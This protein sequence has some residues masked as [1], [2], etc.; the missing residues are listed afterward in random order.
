MTV[1][2]SKSLSPTYEPDMYRPFAEAL[3]YAFKCVSNI[4]VDGLPE[5]KAHIV[6]VPCDNPIPSRRESLF[7]PGLVI[8]S[9]QDARKF[10]QLEEVDAP[11]VSRFISEIEGRSLSGL[12]WEAV[13][14]AV[15]VK[16]NGISMWASLEVFGEQDGK[17][18]ATGG[19]NLRLDE[20]PH[21]S[22]P[23]TGKMNAL[24]YKDTKAS[25]TGV[26]STTLVSFKRS[27]S[28]AGMEIGAG[29]SGGKRQRTK[30]G[31][32]SMNRQS[33]AERDGIYSAEKFSDSFSISHVLNLLVKSESYSN[34]T[35]SLDNANF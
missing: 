1:F 23:A 28:T 7:K 35:A 29:I 32:I 10:H 20:E 6:F 34:H 21:D 9:L 14:S 11:D 5:F 16:W 25:R 22:Q 15:E 12:T 3:N 8:L 30:E 19:A 26:S 2:G 27:A 18:S 33:L 24:R 17:F 4:Q 31:I 13:L